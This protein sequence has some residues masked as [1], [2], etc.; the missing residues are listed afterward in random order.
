MWSHLNLILVRF[1][2]IFVPPRGFEV[3]YFNWRRAF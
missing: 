3:A 2:P 1:D